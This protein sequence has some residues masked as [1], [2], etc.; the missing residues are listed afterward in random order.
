MADLF[1]VEKK[2]EFRQVV[3]GEIETYYRIWATSH[4][5][6]YFHVVVKEDELSKSNAVL[7]A[8]AKL[9]DAI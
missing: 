2:V 8:K 5:G 4:G 3:N 9:L 7:T 6:T 1:K